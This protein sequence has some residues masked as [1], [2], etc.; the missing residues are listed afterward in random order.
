ME[1]DIDYAEAADAAPLLGAGFGAWLAAGRQPERFFEQ[2]PACVAVVMTGVA[3]HHYDKGTFWRFL[4]QALGREERIE[5]E[6][7]WG[8]GYTRAVHELGMATFPGMPR[9]YLGPILMHAGIPMS[10]LEDYLRMIIRRRRADPALD[11]AKLLRWVRGSGRRT[12]IAIPTRSFLLEGTEY[13]HDFVERTID[14]VAR[15]A[16]GADLDVLRLPPQVV[17]HARRLNADRRLDVAGLS[18]RR[19]RALAPAE[20]RLTL[21][22]F[23]Q[24]VQVVLPAPGGSA[25]P[26][27]LAVDQVVAEL[28]GRVL[29]PR[30]PALPAAHPVVRPARAVLVARRSGGDRRELPLVDPAA[31]LLVFTDLGELVPPESPLPPEPVWL[32]HPA[33]A[34]VVGNPPER[35]EADLPLGWAGWLLR[36]VDLTDAVAVEIEGFPSSRR[37]VRGYARPRLLTGDPIAG[38]ASAAGAPVYSRPPALQL[39]GS[40]DFPTLWTVEVRSSEDILL[41]SRTV[42]VTASAVVEDLWEGIARPMNGD[43]GVVVRGPLGRGIRSSVTVVEGLAVTADPPVRPFADDG[44]AEV[45]I[46]VVAG[47][48]TVATPSRMALA[49]D[50]LSASCVVRSPEG[51]TRLLLTPTHYQLRYERV[52]DLHGWSAGPLRLTTEE[53]SAEPGALLIRVPGTVVGELEMTVGGRQVQRLPPAGRNS[54]DTA[55]YRLD[56]A[57]DTLAHHGRA[58]FRIKGVSVASVRP[59]ALAQGVRWDR[60]HLRLEE[61]APVTGLA[62]GVYPVRAPWRRPHVVAVGPDGVV[63]LPPELQAAGPLAVH[64]RIDDPWVPAPW[65]RWPD[66]FHLADGDGHVV[67]ADV[68]ETQLSRFAAGQRDLPPFVGSFRRLWALLGLAGSSSLAEGVPQTCAERLRGA[69]A[70][71]LVALAG[72]R[73]TVAETVTWLIPSGVCAVA[74]PPVEHAARLWS[75]A[76]VIAALA[77][78]LADPCGAAAT[79]ACGAVFAEVRRTARDPFPVRGHWAA[80]GNGGVSGGVLD[81]ARRRAAVQALVEA[82]GGSADP[83]GEV[84]RT[85]LRVLPS[86]AARRF[87][88]G[89]VPEEGQD[90]RGALPAASAAHALLARAAAHGDAASAEAELAFRIS[91]SKLANA[92]PE[93]VA[94]DLILGEVICR[95]KG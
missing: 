45:S 82:E 44:L 63:S 62:A 14:L 83:S 31:P 21:D 75:Q 11:A 57:V 10:C 16:E 27:V 38:A 85:A 36:Y 80:D 90:G 50:V 41:L 15:L 26:W 24:G 91:W 28:P 22:P 78:G 48:G 5:E 55:R 19:S 51:A 1:A 4:R 20:P 23:G 58:E 76:P 34:P 59:R 54:S 64:L 53:V 79:A 52:D 47:P 33:N 37:S 35:M 18:G 70:E 7:H 72:M 89:R 67:S 68:A 9:T 30:E 3:A 92:A 39:L 66:R 77:G 74:A 29:D 13:A 32:L 2:W 88:M 25:D 17:E 84:I 95:S 81:P 94:V 6:R 69:P 73:P 93:I 86:A 71:A 49:P 43:Y 87:L 8:Q 46:D 42:E 60:D 40:A 61:A 12:K 56:R 65:P